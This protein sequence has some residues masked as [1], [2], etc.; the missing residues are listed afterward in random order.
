[1]DTTAPLPVRPTPPHLW[2]MGTI[3]LL[4]NAVGAFDYVMTN[5][6]DH[7]YLARYPAPF[8][9]MIDE[10][11]LW[12]MVAWAIGVWGAVAGSL[13]LLRARLAVHA[14]A[15]SLACLAAGSAYRASVELPAARDS[16]GMPAT[17]LLIWVSAAAFLLY[18]I[19][20]R[21]AGVLR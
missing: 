5:I 14:F 3:G 7:G 4:A 6:R 20:Q 13:L 19:R 1:M 11:P 10:F 12:V 15:M 9:Q 2:V 18:A 17:S 8:V 21:G 16:I